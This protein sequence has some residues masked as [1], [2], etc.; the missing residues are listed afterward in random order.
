MSSQFLESMEKFTFP[1]PGEVLQRLRAWV[2]KQGPWWL[3]S[4]VGHMVILIVLGLVLGTVKAV[5][6]LADVPVFDTVVEDPEPVQEVAK[7]ELSD[8]PLEPTV[9]DTETLMLSDPPDAGES[10]VNAGD[11]NEGGGGLFTTGDETGY[12]GGFDVI[13]SGDGPAQR[14]VGG[15][16]RGVGG[17]KGAGS[18]GEGGFAGRGNR[19][20]LGGGGTRQSELA[21]KAALNWIA[22]HQSRDGSWS[23]HDYGRQ[24]KDQTCTGQ[25]ASHSDAAG[26]AMGLLPFLAAGQTHKSKGPYAKSVNGGLTFLMRQQ[27]QDGN[28]AGGSYT[29]YAHGLATIALCEA[30]GLSKDTHI[31]KSAQGAVNFIERAQ[32][33]S[34]GGWRYTPGEEGDTSVVGWQVMALKSA[35]MA[36]LH[37]NTTALAGAQKFLK[38]ASA[39]TANGLFCYTPGAGPTPTMT[40]VGL[41]CNQ[42]MGTKRDSPLMKEGVDTLMHNLPA[43]ET[44][45][46]YYWY[47]ATQ[48]MH[49]LPGSQWDDWNRRMRKI[50]IESQV[51]E[52]C[53]AGSWDP[54]RPYPDPWGG[55]G[56]RMMMTSLSC[57]TLEVYY[58]YLPLY[59]LDDRGQANPPGE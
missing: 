8:A 10:S 54:E 38:S 53:A 50:L 31:E 11:L 18:G 21:V 12:G 47:Y 49:N 46:I 22:R 44:R 4:M 55:A 24:C 34:T 41:L 7:F 56:G 13:A 40:A 59:Q 29:M 2:L 39:G 19:T 57:L 30:Y 5:Q 16:G 1:S 27:N 6:S 20:G 51:K 15:V 58:R 14:G 23:I 32:H 3:A 37:V 35:Q 43:R 28:L 25:G 42:Y 52:G 48:V 33:P 26:T 9:L 36:G 45:S 17:G